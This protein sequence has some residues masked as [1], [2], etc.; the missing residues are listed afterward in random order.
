MQD[1]PD[2]IPKHEETINTPDIPE[3]VDPYK[4]YP[5]TW[6]ELASTNGNLLGNTFAHLTA[7]NGRPW[8]QAEILNLRNNLGET[9]AH[10]MAKGGN[11]TH[12]PDLLLTKDQYG[13]LPIHAYAM[14]GNDC[15]VFSQEQLMT[16]GA[17]G[18]TVYHMAATQ[19]QFL[20][21]DEDMWLLETDDG[22]T[23]AHFMASGGYTF[24]DN[25][26]I[27]LRGA[28]DITVAHYMAENGHNFTDNETLILESTEGWTVAHEMGDS[29][30]WPPENTWRLET[31]TKW[32]VAHA[33]ARRGYEFVDEE[34]LSLEDINGLAVR[35]V[36][37]VIGD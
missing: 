25:K 16:V 33:M 22:M 13:N 31:L 11:M 8:F 3:G 19:G 35:D 30:T 36:P 9:V 21:A 14:N 18:S 20:T 10:A 29:Y 1:T 26:W 24:H 34:I 28:N 2:L 12:D 6:F 23:L 4:Q 17:A 7:L 5:I 37:V 27:H 32:T 15:S